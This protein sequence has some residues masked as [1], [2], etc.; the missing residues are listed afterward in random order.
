MAKKLVIGLV[1][2]VCAGKSAVT[3]AFERRG[4]QVYDADR[5]VHELYA[6]PDV[7]DEVRALLGADVF[8]TDGEVDRKKIGA[9]VFADPAK[10]KELT[11]RILFPR[12]LAV[13]EARLQEFRAPD[14]AAPA[15]IVDAP[16]LFE[17][18]RETLCDRVLFV[19]A[20]LARRDAWAQAQRGWA[21]GEVERRE[22]RLLNEAQKR[23]RCTDVLENDG[24]LAELDKKA[25]ACWQMWFGG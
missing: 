10:L 22:A 15:L 4:A 9:K 13:L 16:T 5:V 11:A 1:G 7:K 3:A 17:A 14:C 21:K 19:A 23:A 24:S 2:Q 25:G 6:R 20:P 18:G 12:T 8:G